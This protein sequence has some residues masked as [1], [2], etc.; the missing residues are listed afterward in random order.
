MKI[1]RY[2]FNFGLEIG[3]SYKERVANNMNDVL[4]EVHRDAA[5]V[6]DLNRILINQKGSI[7]KLVKEVAELQ[8]AVATIT[9]VLDN[10]T[11]K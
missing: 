3:P 7:I 1:G 2:E 10:L 6:R 4:K 11:K 9:K 8:D 5:Y